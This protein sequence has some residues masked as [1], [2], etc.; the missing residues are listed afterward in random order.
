M[1]GI[2]DERTLLLPHYL[3]LSFLISPISF[4][5]VSSQTFQQ[6]LVSAIGPILTSHF[7]LG[8]GCYAYLLVAYLFFNVIHR[9]MLT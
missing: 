7:T 1:A 6:S 4:I 9:A 8:Y 5:Y 2:P 3:S